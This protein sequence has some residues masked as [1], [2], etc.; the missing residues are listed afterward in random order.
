MK[1]LILLL[2]V[3]GIILLLA[4]SVEIRDFLIQLF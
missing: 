4:Y 2:A 3:I 1:Q